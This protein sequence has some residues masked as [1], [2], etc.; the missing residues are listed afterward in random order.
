MDKGQLSRILARLRRRKYLRAQASAEHKKRLL[1]CLTD[2]GWRAFEALET[3]AREQMGA[4]LE[5]VETDARRRLVAALREAR[6]ALDR[7][8]SPERGAGLRK[9]GPGDLGW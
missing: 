5:R 4:I 1:L 7:E 3:A 6:S 2:A 9:A 8:R